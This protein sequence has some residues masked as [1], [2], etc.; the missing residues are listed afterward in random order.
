MP[1]RTDLLCLSP[2]PIFHPFLQP[3]LAGR[4]ALSPPPSHL[5]LSEADGGTEVLQAGV[6]SGDTA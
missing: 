4:P 2:R 5:P 3:L 1:I 6:G